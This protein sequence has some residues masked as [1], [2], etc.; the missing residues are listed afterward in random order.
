[1]SARWLKMSLRGEWGSPKETVHS[2]TSAWP[3]TRAI[4]E[5]EVFVEAALNLPRTP[6]TC[7]QPLG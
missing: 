5:H 1:M 6:S 7:T 3:V 2:L 4:A